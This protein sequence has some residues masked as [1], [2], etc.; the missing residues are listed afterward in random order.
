MINRL[1]IDFLVSFVGGVSCGTEV[2]VIFRAN[3]YGFLIFIFLLGR[4]NLL[5]IWRF[6]GDNFAN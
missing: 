4:T 1:D 5:L 3:F 6:L 2:H